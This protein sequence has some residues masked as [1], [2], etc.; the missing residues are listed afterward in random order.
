MADSLSRAPSSCL[1]GTGATF[2]IPDVMVDKRMTKLIA[3]VIDG[4]TVDIR[5]APMERAW[6]DATD[7]RFAYRCLPLNI[8]NAHGWEIL[9]PSGFSVYWDGRA[10]K[11]AVYVI[12]DPGATRGDPSGFPP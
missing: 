4:H 3:Y 10:I 12:P 6:M 7:Q 1:C 5:P 9:A 2:A 11:E 8:A